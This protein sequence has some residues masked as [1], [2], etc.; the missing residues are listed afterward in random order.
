MD[1]PKRSANGQ[2]ADEIWQNQALTFTICKVREPMMI[3]SLVSRYWLVLLSI[4]MIIYMLF[5]VFSHPQPKLT[6][7]D[8]KPS[9]T[10][11]K[12]SVGGIGVVEPQS[13]N[14]TIGTAKSG[15]VTDIYVKVG[16]H[17]AK[18]EPLFTIDTRDAKAR[19]AAAKAKLLYIKSKLEES[20]HQLTFYQNI[21]D[22]RA[23]STQELTQRK[24]S[25]QI[26]EAEVR[27]AESEIKQIETELEQL[28]VK[29][30]IDGTI[31]QVSLHKGE[32][33][34]AGTLS[35][36]LI[37]MGNTDV[38]HVR[39]E[40]DETNGQAILPTAKAVGYLREGNSK[41]ISLSFVRIEPL[42]RLKKS[43]SNQGNELVDTRVFVILYSF[44]NTDVNARIGQQMDVFID[45]AK[46]NNQQ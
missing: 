14:I 20:K 36:P 3:K 2:I 31:L 32:F 37:V 1:T 21:D 26:N 43:I 39:V 38:M 9:S 15:I 29:A 30:P 13:E 42:V 11:Y 45:D 33:A 12:D 4:L 24:D 17:V 34:Q 40:V 16:Q 7:P 46:K 22:R 27:M 18:N 28:T 19:L 35:D 44:E 25:V 8:I 41:P 5:S 10:P 23:I 6:E